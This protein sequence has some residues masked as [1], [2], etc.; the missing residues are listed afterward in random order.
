MAQLSRRAQSLWGKSSEDGMGYPLVAHMLDVAACAWEILDREPSSTLGLYATDLGVARARECVCALVGLHDL[1][2]ASPAFQSKWSPGAE[3]ARAHGLTWDPPVGDAPHGQVTEK[4]LSPLLTE[5]GWPRRTARGVAAAVGAHHGF[6]HA[7][8]E[9]TRVRSSSRGGDAW[10]DTRR[11]LVD[12]LIALLDVDEL[13]QASRLDGAAYMRLAG[14]TSFADWIGSDA[15][16]FGSD[17][18][19]DDLA[20]HYEEAR[21]KARA[22]LDAIGWSHRVPLKSRSVSFSEAFPFDPRPLQ[23]TASALVS[24]AESPSL[25][26]IEAPTGEGKTEAALHAHLLLQG[27]VGHRGMYVALPTMATGNAMFERTR[28]FLE[29]CER[30]DPP[31]LQL[32]H[33]ASLLNESFAD[34]RLRN[35]QAETDASEDRVGHVV[36]REWFTHKKRALLSEY[37]VGTVDQALLSILNLKHQ[38]VRLWGL[39]NRV[40]VLDEVHAYDTY[41][42]GLLDTLLRWLRALGSSAIVMSAT[43]P[44]SRRKTVIET[45]GGDASAS[46]EYP[47]V[48]VVSGGAT[49]TKTFRARDMPTYQL[50]A[51]PRDAVALADSLRRAAEHGGCVACIVNTVQR[52]QAVYTA[53]GHGDPIR[54]DHVTYGKRVGPTQAMLFH[55]RYPAGER[56]AREARVLELFGKDAANRPSSAVLIATQVVEQSLDLDFDVLYSDLAPVDLLLQRAGRLHRHERPRPVSH[57]AP[58]LHIAGIDTNETPP[59]LSEHAWDRIYEPYVLLRTWH[60]L[61]GAREI[62]PAEDVSELIARVYDSEEIPDDLSEDTRG[63]FSEARDKMTRRRDDEAHWATRVGLGRPDDYLR[64]VAPIPLADEDDEGFPDALRARTRLGDRSVTAVPLYQVGDRLYVDAGGAQPVS[65]DTEPSFPEARRLYMRSVSLS[66][67]DVVAELTSHDPPKG[68]EESP[69]LRKCRPLRLS[70]GAARLGSA[71]VTLDHELGI[72]Y[73]NAWEGDE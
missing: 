52:A 3:R 57:E 54:G 17:A 15:S 39:A 64:N 23:E 24:H 34:I 38:F 13:P 11:E 22:A 62:R 28:S 8:E 12:V 14:L 35:V 44:P 19:A 63:A 10:D 50:R 41:T 69:L 46:G 43:L 58:V 30:S 5:R 61:R 4:C 2:K 56:Q 32:L 67:R 33:G 49:R 20:A 27:V 42:S 68:W 65:V 29:T 26:L 51:A 66:R 59:D 36:A 9:L 53:L 18:R 21:H 40:V 37:G 55:A 31:D 45:Y 47:H 71:V 1:G 72:V 70:D 60:A 48:T 6:R 7:E 25:V 73:A 16:R